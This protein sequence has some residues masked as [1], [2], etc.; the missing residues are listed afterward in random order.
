[1]EDTSKELNA[2]TYA[3]TIKR[4]R[5]RKVDLV[6]FYFLFLIFIFFSIFFSILELRVGV[7]TSKHK[8]KGMK[9]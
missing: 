3:I 4:L 6:S 2:K 7:T 5:L 1:M 8:K 9:G